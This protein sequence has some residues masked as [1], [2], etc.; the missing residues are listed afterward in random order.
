MYFLYLCNEIFCMLS[1]FCFCLNSYII[2]EIQLDF[3]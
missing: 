2:N 1:A 3:A